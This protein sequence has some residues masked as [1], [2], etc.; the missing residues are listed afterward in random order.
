MTDKGGGKSM[1]R[2]WSNKIKRKTTIFQN[3]A[4]YPLKVRTQYITNNEPTAAVVPKASRFAVS[5]FLFLFGAMILSRNLYRGGQ[6]CQNQSDQ[7]PIPIRKFLWL[8][9]AEVAEL[10]II[11]TVC[12]KTYAPTRLQRYENP[13]CHFFFLL[14]L[15]GRPV[16][17]II[18]RAQ[19]ITTVYKTLDMC[20]N[21]SKLFKSLPSIKDTGILRE[22]ELTQFPFQLIRGTN[23]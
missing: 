16:S 3:P 1:E 6:N 20:C 23:N 9:F 7:C 21:I 17:I 8:D 19:Y 2:E 5:Y 11:S 4:I 12:W 18:T 22:T 13:S 10:L 15:L 14:L